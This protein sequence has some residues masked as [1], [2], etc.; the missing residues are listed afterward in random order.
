M[1]S[2]LHGFGY[3]QDP[4]QA[5]LKKQAV[6]FAVRRFGCAEAF[7]PAAA[8]AQRKVGAGVAIRMEWWRGLEFAGGVAV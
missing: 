2:V 5:A 6:G 8:A 7:S 3:R 1:R 4:W